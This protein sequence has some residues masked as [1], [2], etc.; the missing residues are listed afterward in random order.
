MDDTIYKRVCE[1]ARLGGEHGIGLR[2]GAHEVVKA[3][4]AEKA[5]VCFLAEDCS[6]AELKKLIETFCAN[7]SIPLIKCVSREVLGQWVGLSKLKPDGT[8]RK[9]VKCA[10]A[11]ITSFGQETPELVQFRAEYNI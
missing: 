11:A 9:D 8:I 3:L 10:V 6:E 2:R 5:L 7:N 1:V 4:D